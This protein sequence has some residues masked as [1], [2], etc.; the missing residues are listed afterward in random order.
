MGNYYL[1]DLDRFIKRQLK[2][3]GYVRYMDDL[4]YLQTLLTPC[5]TGKKKL[6]ITLKNT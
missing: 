4:F 5:K 1:N 6:N 3:K 2:V